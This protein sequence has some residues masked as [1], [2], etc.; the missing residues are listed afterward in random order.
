MRDRA[1]VWIAPAPLSLFGF[2]LA[3]AFFWGEKEKVGS[4]AVSVLGLKQ[5]HVLSSLIKV[6]QLN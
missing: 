2:K 1:N 6:Q 5:S 4:F 3:A